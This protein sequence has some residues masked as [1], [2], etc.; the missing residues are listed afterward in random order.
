MNGKS[1]EVDN[2]DAEGRLVLSGTIR[3]SI[4]YTSRCSEDPFYIF[5]MP[6]ITHPRNTN[7]TLS[8]MSPPSQGTQFCRSDAQTQLNLY[9]LQCHGRRPGFSLLWCFRC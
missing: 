7:P 4:V 1:V 5:Q 6:S 8:S 3:P 2:T 9:H